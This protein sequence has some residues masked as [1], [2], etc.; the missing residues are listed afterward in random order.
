MRNV[1]KIRTFYEK[2]KKNSQV[3]SGVIEE[4]ILINFNKLWKND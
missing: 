1:E 3:N 2:I 4:K